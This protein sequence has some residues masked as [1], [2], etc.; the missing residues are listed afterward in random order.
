VTRILFFLLAA[1]IIQWPALA[2]DTTAVEM[3]ISWQ[4]LAMVILLAAAVGFLW[5]NC[6]AL[7][8]T[9]PAPTKPSLNPIRENRVYSITNSNSV[10]YTV[11]PD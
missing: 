9:E 2:L 3:G 1:L 6:V 4:L 11:D 5:L 10:P 8:E 7:K